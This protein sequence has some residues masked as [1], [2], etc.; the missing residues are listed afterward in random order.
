[1]RTAVKR[2]DY[3]Q[4][5]YEQMAALVAAVTNRSHD[6]ELFTI[7]QDSQN[8]GRADLIEADKGRA[9]YLIEKSGLSDNQEFIGSVTKYF[10]TENGQRKFPVY[11]QS[12]IWAKVGFLPVLDAANPNIFGDTDSLDWSKFYESSHKAKAVFLPNAANNDPTFENSGGF[13][14]SLHVGMTFLTIRDG[15]E[16]HYFMTKWDFDKLIPLARNPNDQDHT[17][18]SKEDFLSKIETHV[19]HQGLKNILK[20]VAS[21]QG[22]IC[23]LALL[24]IPTA[25]NPNPGC[26]DLSLASDVAIWLDNNTLDAVQLELLRS[27]FFVKLERNKKQEKPAKFDFNQDILPFL[28]AVQSVSGNNDQEVLKNIAMRLC[29]Y[30]TKQPGWNHIYELSSYMIQLETK[31]LSAVLG[32]IHKILPEDEFQ[33][34][35]LFTLFRAIHKFVPNYEVDKILNSFWGEFEK[36]PDAD[37]NKLLDNFN[38]LFLGS[39]FSILDNMDTP[40]DNIKRTVKLACEILDKPYQNKRLV[41]DIVVMVFAVLLFPIVM[42]MLIANKSVSGNFRLFKHSDTSNMLRKVRDHLVAEIDKE[43]A[44]KLASMPSKASDLDINSGPRPEIVDDT[45]DMQF[46]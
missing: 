18:L 12:D 7:E 42:P 38:N 46:R 30:S 41:K 1:M 10:S 33:F 3:V 44:A 17:D 14:I 40:K 35:Y 2:S 25:T 22:E 4:L 31:N 23:N 29:I 37:K 43:S 11:Q 9:P 5:S 16:N 21:V 45:R 36:L 28:K 24:F 8:K 34:L 39:D 20:S 32:I 15:V 6:H 19:K 26:D 27:I 13:D